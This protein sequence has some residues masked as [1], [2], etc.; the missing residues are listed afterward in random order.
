M[1]KIDNLIKNYKN[2]QFS[3][4]SSTGSDYKSFETKYRN[5]LKEICKNINVELV[6]F[7][8]NHYSFSAFMKRDNNY[9]Y[10][11]ISDVR[12][13][14]SWKDHILIRTAEN[15][16]DYTGGPN[17]YTILKNL[18]SKIDEMLQ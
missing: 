8:K 4:G 14:N 17:Q 7:S 9:V 18:S 12:G 5:I 2:H 16:K 10:L 15:D 1:K 11:S 6:K 3:S 13:N